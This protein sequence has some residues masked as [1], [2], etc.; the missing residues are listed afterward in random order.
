MKKLIAT[1][2]LCAFAVTG[3]MAHESTENNPRKPTEEMAK[4]PAPKKG[5]VKPLGHSGGTDRYGCHTNHSTGDYH[6][7]NR[8]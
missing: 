4:V 7:H 5:E 2:A 3:A 1:V 8:K 6:C